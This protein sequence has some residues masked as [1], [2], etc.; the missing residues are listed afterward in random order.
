[1]ACP[2]GKMWFVRFGLSLKKK[3]DANKKG[4]KKDE[5]GG[6]FDIDMKSMGSGMMEMMGSFTLL[7]LSSMM[8]MANINFTKEELLKI[9]KQLNRIKKPI[10]KT[11]EEKQKATKTKKAVAIGAA[12]TGAAVAAGVVIGKTV[13]KKKK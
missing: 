4:K 6:G 12:V 10:R 1:M 13:S 8:G 3:M 5:K 11:E 2:A 9:N 7:R